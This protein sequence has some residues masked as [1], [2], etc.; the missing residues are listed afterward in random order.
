M[1]RADVI[2]G[3]VLAL[4]G[5]VCLFV[6]IP[7]QVGSEAG[8]A[9]VAPDVFPLTLMALLTGLAVLLCVSRLASR[10]KEDEP[11]PLRTENF[12]YIIAASV[13]LAGVFLAITYLGFIAGSI[14][15][16][17]IGMLV[18]E[19]RRYPVRLVAVSLAAPVAIWAVFRHLFTVL[20]P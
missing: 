11:A 17:A 1:R 8:S 12:F 3:A 13:V 5:L 7:A 14:I 20:L 10:S 6:I 4:F 16:V 18:M 19:G 9:G 15:S 2:S